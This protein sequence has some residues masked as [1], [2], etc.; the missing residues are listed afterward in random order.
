MRPLSLD[1]PKPLFPIAGRAII[2]HCIQALS[3]CVIPSE[4]YF[5]PLDDHL[6]RVLQSRGPPGSAPDRIL[7]VTDSGR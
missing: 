1:I 2:W 5:H 4:L 6:T 3:K 7:C